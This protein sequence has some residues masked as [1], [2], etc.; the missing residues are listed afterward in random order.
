MF[1]QFFIF[2]HFYFLYGLYLFSVFFV[3]FAEL[4]QRSTLWRFA[5]FLDA[6]SADCGNDDRE[7]KKGR[8][9]KVCGS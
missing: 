2:G 1:K 8:A 9:K 3:I 4:S 7:K 6:T 5:I